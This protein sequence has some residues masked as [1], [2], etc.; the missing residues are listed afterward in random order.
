MLNIIIN[1]CYLIINGKQRELCDYLYMNE[2]KIENNQL[3]IKLIEI[4]HITN[5]SYMF[6]NCSSL[7]SLPDISKWN[8][9]N[10]TDMRYMFSKCSSLVS[11]P[12]ISKWKLNKKLYKEDMF[13]GCNERIIPE[14]FK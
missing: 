4:K 3:K 12:D 6:G 5:M 1:N 2:I 13:K 9:A 11:L 7:V 8:T 10:V 14:K